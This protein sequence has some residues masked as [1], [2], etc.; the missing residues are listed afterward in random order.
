LRLL[1]QM[2]HERVTSTEGRT[3]ERRSARG[4]VLR[5]TDI[6]MIY[7]KRYNDYS[8]PGGGVEPDE[9]LIAGLHRELAEETGATDIEVLQ[10]FG[11]VEEYRP[12]HKPEYDL[13]HMLSYF[14]VCTANADFN[15]ATPEAYE[16]TNGSVPVWVDIQEAIRHNR[17]VMA[18]Q[19][20][21]MGFSIARETLV[22]DLVAEELLG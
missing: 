22:L 20:A 11:A 5:G 18:K 8:F 15:N 10:A 6:L 16:V 3:F 7:T 9:E 12:S 2:I 4:I 21:S 1:Q 13:I 14:Y 17:D 19:D